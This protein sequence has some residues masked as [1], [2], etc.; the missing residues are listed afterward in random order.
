M[1]HANI[2]RFFRGKS[3]ILDALI[4]EWLAK[5][6]VFVESIAQR[7]ASAAER[8][9]AVVLELHRKRRQKL[10]ED[11]EFY[12]AFRRVIEMRPDFA[13]KR[14]EKI[15]RVFVKLIESGMASGEFSEVNAQETAVVLKD[16]TSQFLHPFMI[17]ASLGEDTETRAKNVVRYV[18]AGLAKPRIAAREA[19]ATPLRRRSVKV[20]S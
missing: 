6:E 9:E 12:E 2:Y 18:L 11:A 20:A 15:L 8:I 16:A 17:K 10:Q 5:I 14:R 7:Q 19:E 4:E 3:E 13:A 1:S